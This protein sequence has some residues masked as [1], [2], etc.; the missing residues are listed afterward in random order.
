MPDPSKIP[1]PSRQAPDEVYQSINQH[2]D[3]LRKFGGVDRDNHPLFAR[4][5]ELL[6]QSSEALGAIVQQA[7]E[8]IQELIHSEAP[9]SE[10][11]NADPAPSCDPFSD[12]C[13]DGEMYDMNG[14][15]IRET[16]DKIFVP[17]MGTSLQFFKEYMGVI[18]EQGYIGIFNKSNNFIDDFVQLLNDRLEASLGVRVGQNPSIETLKHHLKIAVDDGRRL[19][20]IGHSQGAAIIAAALSYLVREGYTEDRFANVYVTTYGS[21]GTAFPRGPHYTHYVIM[22]D[23]VPFLAMTAD[24]FTFSPVGLGLSY[25]LWRD[26][27]MVNTIVLP[28][29]GEALTQIHEVETYFETVNDEPVI[30]RLDQSIEELTA[31]LQQGV[32]F[33]DTP[34]DDAPPAEPSPM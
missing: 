20:M 18:G 11:Q 17:G 10:A 30:S 28:T 31:K 8:Q 4:V 16:P 29:K 21:A 13:A 24:V 32:L 14:N 23:P 1:P 6:S 26:N 3:I 33:G 2:L 15:H 22:G 5:S 27:S 12:D 9:Q 34:M 25:L 19:E 7:E